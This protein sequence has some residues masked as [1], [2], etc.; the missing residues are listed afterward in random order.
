MNQKCTTK[1]PRKTLQLSDHSLISFH[2]MYLHA[3]Y[4]NTHT[5]YVLV[6]KLNS[7]QRLLY[8]RTDFFLPEEVA[9]IRPKIDKTMPHHH[10]NLDIEFSQNRQKYVEH[11]SCTSTKIIS[12]F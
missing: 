6:L 9:K 2:I 7:I 8:R 4:R 12:E 10:S 1:L 11:L 5:N 3:L